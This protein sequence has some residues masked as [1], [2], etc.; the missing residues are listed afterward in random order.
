MTHKLYYD[1]AYAVSFESPI[2]EKAEIEEIGR[3]HV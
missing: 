1:D 3:A 2:I